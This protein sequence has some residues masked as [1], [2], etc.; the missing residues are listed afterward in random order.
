MSVKKRGK[1]WQVHAVRTIDGTKTNIRESFK[2]KPDAEKRERELLGKYDRGEIAPGGKAPAFSEWA[3]EFLDVYPDANNKPSETAAKKMIVKSH[4][5]PFFG[6]TPIDRISS[7]DVERFKAHQRRDKAALK[8]INNRLTVL[9]RMLTVA[10]EWGKLG[11]APK[12]KLVKLPS[13]HH[14]F[15]DF[16]ESEA[17]L[18]ATAPAWRPMILIALR[19]GLRRGELLALRWEDID[20]KAGTIHVQR[21]VWKDEIGTPKGGRSRRVPLSPEA[22]TALKALPSRFAK[23][24][25]F[26]E[27]GERILSTGEIQ[28]ALISASKG[29]GLKRVGWHV[30]RHTYASQLAM[31]GLSLRVLQEW[32]GH[33]TIAMTE[34]YAHLSPSHD[35]AAVVALDRG[36][37]SIG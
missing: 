17:L 22:A 30:L 28:Q 8:S 33:S 7:G 25:V 10:V 24:Y 21:N 12:V 6:D 26:G 3:R 29:A 14:R 32:L 9:R 1:S 31:S 20:L 18:D 13:V 4:L 2:T 15:L 23:G 19:T 35:H 36:R 37:A 16:T 34:R 5:I 11:H 27:G